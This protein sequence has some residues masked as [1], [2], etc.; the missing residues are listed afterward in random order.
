MK[1]RSG[2]ERGEGGESRIRAKHIY[3]KY[4]RD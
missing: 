4:N 3:I 1:G 2:G